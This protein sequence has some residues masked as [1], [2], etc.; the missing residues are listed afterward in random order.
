VPGLEQPF[1]GEHPEAGAPPVA[2][3]APASGERKTVAGPR[4]DDETSALDAAIDEVF[5]K[6][7]I[8]ELEK[9]WVE[10]SK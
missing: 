4:I 9:D 8:R 3:S 7:D 10:W 1:P 2:G 5:S 6:I